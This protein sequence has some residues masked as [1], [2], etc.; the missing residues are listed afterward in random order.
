MKRPSK[1]K[2]PVW[3]M[4]SV[5]MFVL[6]VF[7]VVAISTTLGYSDGVLPLYLTAGLAGLVIGPVLG[8]E[9]AS[10]LSFLLKI[11]RN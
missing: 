11:P 7:A 10:F 2:F 1:Q 3:F 4:C 6:V 8:I 9:V 5:V